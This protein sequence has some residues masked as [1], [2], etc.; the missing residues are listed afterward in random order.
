MSSAGCALSLTGSLGT[1]SRHPSAE[2]SSD[3]TRSRTAFKR[4]K[5]RLSEINSAILAGYCMESNGNEGLS[6]LIL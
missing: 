6:T 4:S 1:A 5:R 2:K 3:C